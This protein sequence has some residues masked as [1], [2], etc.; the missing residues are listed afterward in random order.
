MADVGLQAVERQDDPLVRRG[1]APETLDVEHG[2]GQ[3]CIIAVEQVSD[4][5]LADGDRALVQQLVYLGNR[6]VVLV[7]PGADL[8]DDV[9]TERVVR[10]GEAAF[11]FG[12]IRGVVA[13][14][15][16]V[17]AA[18]DTQDQFDDAIQG[19]EATTIAIL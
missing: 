2:E 11:D 9:E 15:F 18:P 10:Q 6:A 8:G 5:P 7:A 16:G 14:A 4:A 12:T 1:E 19:D 13:G 17:L 3:Q